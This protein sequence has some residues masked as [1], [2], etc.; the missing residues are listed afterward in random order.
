MVPPTGK[1]QMNKTGTN[2]FNFMQKGISDDELMNPEVVD[3]L[4]TG[5]YTHLT[6]PTICSV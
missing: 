2:R 3:G 1:K 6:L 5:S 4:E